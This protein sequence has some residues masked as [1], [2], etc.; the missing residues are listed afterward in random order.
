MKWGVTQDKKNNN[1]SK[2]LEIK[3]LWPNLFP[4]VRK[5]DIITYRQEVIR[6]IQ[7]NSC[8]ILIEKKLKRKQN[9]TI[10]QK[11]NAEYS[12]SS[13]DSSN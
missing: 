5:S 10:K 6:T 4:I 3:Y 1:L 9:Q 7:Y 12:T 13:S 8:N 11:Q 2:F